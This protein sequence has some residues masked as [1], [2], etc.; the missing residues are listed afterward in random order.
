MAGLPEFANKGPRTETLR[1]TP[2]KLQLDTVPVQIV[3]LE[4]CT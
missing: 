2:S 3:G 4:I 1:V